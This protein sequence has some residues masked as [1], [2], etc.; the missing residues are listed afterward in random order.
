[1]QNTKN[2]YMEFDPL[3]GF[4]ILNTLLPEYFKTAYPYSAMSKEKIIH[5]QKTIDI[6]IKQTCAKN[7]KIKPIK[8]GEQ[9]I[10]ES[11]FAP[12]IQIYY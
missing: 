9:S 6:L 4:E 8:G 11:N 2:K 10:A 3:D 1:M 12:I 5:T 7:E